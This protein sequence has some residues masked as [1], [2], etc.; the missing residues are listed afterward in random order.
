MIFKGPLTT[1]I[2][3][4][5]LFGCHKSVATTALIYDLVLGAPD[6]PQYMLSLVI[7]ILR[8]RFRRLWAI[9]R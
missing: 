2:R 4:V 6:N 1:I 9:R 8:Y 5:I 3:L 7:M